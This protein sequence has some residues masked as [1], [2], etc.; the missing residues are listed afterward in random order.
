MN[1]RKIV[2]SLGLSILLALPGI[3]SEISPDISSP[4][5]EAVK[6]IHKT[7]KQLEINFDK[8]VNTEIKLKFMVNGDRQLIVLSTGNSALDLTL[9]KALNYQSIE[10]NDLIPYKVYILPIR[11]EKK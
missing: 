8:Y 6:K 11:F 3:S 10:G 7:I 9:K 1:I 5:L 2:L 4:S